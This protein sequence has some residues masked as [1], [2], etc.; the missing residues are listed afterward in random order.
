LADFDFAAI[1]QILYA[2]LGAQ[3]LFHPDEARLFVHLSSDVDVNQAEHK[4]LV[5][6]HLKSKP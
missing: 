5:D 1:L 6:A 3:S 4:K 2:K